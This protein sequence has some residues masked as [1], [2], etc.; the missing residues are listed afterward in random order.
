M[1]YRT[2]EILDRTDVDASGTKTVDIN[3]RDPISRIDI[4][5][6]TYIYGAMQAQPGAVM[7]KIELT[8]GSEVLFSMSA[9]EAQAINIYDRRVRTMNGPTTNGGTWQMVTASIDFGR[10]LWDRELAF[11]PTR[12]NNPQLKI[13][14]DE[15]ACYAGSL[16][17]FLECFAHCFDEMVISPIGFLMSKN[18]YTYTPA[19]DNSFKDI[20]LPTDYPYRQLLVRP[21]NSKKDPLDVIDEARL[22]EENLKRIV[23]DEELNRYFHRMRGVWEQVRE[24]W[25]EAATPEA[26]TNNKWFTPTNY[27]TIA[28]AHSQGNYADFQTVAAMRGGWMDWRG[29]IGFQF[30]GDV[31]G[32]LPNHTIQFPFGVQS[33]IDSWYDAQ[34]KESI[35]LRLH[36]N[37]QYANAEVSVL[38]QQLRR[39]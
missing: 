14:Y 18:H 33:E 4:T 11:D 6:H 22:S 13:T 28:K 5:F 34:L 38:L 35:K 37:A 21:Y 23:F 17:N 29:S 25:C 8:D 15:D 12:F 10:W 32:Y 26:E 31:V 39:Y 7:P 1:K 27:M 19:D 24:E 3:V 2:T 30:Y 9:L 20:S 16:F 36:S